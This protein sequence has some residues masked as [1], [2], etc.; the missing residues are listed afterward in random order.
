MCRFLR[1]CEKTYPCEVPPRDKRGSIREGASG[2]ERSLHRRVISAY[3]VL[4]R[5]AVSVYFIH[6]TTLRLSQ[7]LFQEC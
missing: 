7:K 2:I 6:I 3:F 1:Y 5:D 4:T